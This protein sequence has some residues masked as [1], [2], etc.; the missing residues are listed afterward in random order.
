MLDAGA[1]SFDAIASVG[2][3]DF[4]FA[5]DAGDDG[6]DGVVATISGAFGLGHSKLHKLDFGLVGFGNHGVKV[7]LFGTSVGKNWC[8]WVTCALVTCLA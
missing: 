8:A 5:H 2:D 7:Y 4:L 1:G 3:D 6:A